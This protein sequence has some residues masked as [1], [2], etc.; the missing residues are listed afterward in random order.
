MNHQNWPSEARRI[1]AGIRQRAFDITVAQNGAYLG[2]ACSAAEIIA[3]LRAG[4]MRESEGDVLVLS[5]AHYCLALYAAMV[6]TGELDPD[7]FE[8]YNADGSHVEM[9]G[10]TGA[11]G[12][13]FTTGSLAQ[14]LSQAIGYAL[15]R[16][17]RKRGGRVFVFISDGELEEGQTWEAMMSLAHHNLGEITLVLD[18][19]DSQV[20]GSPAGIMNLE[21]I[22]EKFAA[23]GVETHE[24]DGHD[25]EAIHAAVGAERGERARAVI[26]RT[27][28]WQGIPSLRTRHNLHFVRFRDSEA[29]L[30]QKDLNEHAGGVR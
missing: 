14:G 4:V 17:S 27:N 19:N 28:I 10:G 9:I 18:A 25:I 2:Q 5:P 11:P 30:A 3:T 24:V 8:T 6:E 20:D 1:A 21:P 15:A 23:F 26:C 29:E 13:L 22:A 12:M 7:V 16:R